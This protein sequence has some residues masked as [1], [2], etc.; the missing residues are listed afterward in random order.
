MELTK[1]QKRALKALERK[2]HKWAEQSC[3]GGVS[4]RTETRRNNIVQKEIVD[5]LG[6]R[7]AGFFYNG[8]PRGYALKIDPEHGSTDGFVTDW[9]G[10]G[11]LSRPL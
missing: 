4:E 9:G 11:I 6:E 3:N 2:A 5:I 7:P 1:T 10:Y 8:D